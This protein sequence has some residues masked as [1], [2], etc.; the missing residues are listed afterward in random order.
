MRPLFM[1]HAEND[2]HSNSA[3]A[4]VLWDARQPEI[5][6]ELPA[7]KPFSKTAEGT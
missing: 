7:A 4:G 3:P 5:G 1:C 2:A 6:A